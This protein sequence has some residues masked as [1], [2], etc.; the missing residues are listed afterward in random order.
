MTTCLF[1]KRGGEV[2]GHKSA[3]EGINCRFH[4]GKAGFKKCIGSDECDKLTISKSGTCT[5][6]GLKARKEAEKL[7]KKVDKVDRKVRKAIVEVIEQKIED[8]HK[9]DEEFDRLIKDRD[10][11]ATRLVEV[12]DKLKLLADFMSL[13]VKFCSPVP[14][15]DQTF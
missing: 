2:C 1:I 7:E 15:L 11:L 12:N 8:D 9:C 14:I 4:V 13:N 3:P 10:F 6:C 5:E